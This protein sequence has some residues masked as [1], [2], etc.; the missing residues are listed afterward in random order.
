MRSG[1][2]FLVAL[3]GCMLYAAIA[4]AQ[5]P[6]RMGLVEDWSQMH[7]IFTNGGSPEAVARA[8]AD[9]R[10]LQQWLKRSSYLFRSQANRVSQ[11]SE[12]QDWFPRLPHRPRK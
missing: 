11:E 9:P 12:F 6:S 3:G 8:Q 5:T 7:V 10:S 2:L 4:S 1:I